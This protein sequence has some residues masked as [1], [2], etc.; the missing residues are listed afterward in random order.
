MRQEIKKRFCFIAYHAFLVILLNVINISRYFSFYFVQTM[1]AFY[2][3]L[4]LTAIIFH[5]GMSQSLINFNLRI[6]PQIILKYCE[7]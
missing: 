2:F 3:G 5:K 7:V 1:L 6:T 4:N